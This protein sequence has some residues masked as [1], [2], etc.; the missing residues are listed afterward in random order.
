MKI[1]LL[2]S[3]FK[4]PSASKQSQM[5]KIHLS[6]PFPSV[7]AVDMPPVR[8]TIARSMNCFVSFSLGKNLRG[9]EIQKDEGV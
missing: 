5:N 9:I 6:F 1:A 4:N 7:L 8:R 3:F 2:N